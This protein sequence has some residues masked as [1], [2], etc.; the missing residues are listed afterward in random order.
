MNFQGPTLV[1]VS[2][3]YLLYNVFTF[4]T[5]SSLTEKIMFYLKS[6]RQKGQ[7]GKCCLSSVVCASPEVVFATP[8]VVFA[9]TAVVFATPVVV[10]ASSSTVLPS[11]SLALSFTTASGALLLQF[12]KEKFFIVKIKWQ[13]EKVIDPENYMT[14][15]KY[16]SLY[17]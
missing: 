2:F 4:D 1:K 10:F 15:V 11:S 13:K 16:V 17:N 14:K 8:E 5:L 7:S 9:S 12:Q 3:K 6:L